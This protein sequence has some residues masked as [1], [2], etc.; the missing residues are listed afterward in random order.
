[1]LDTPMLQSAYESAELVIYAFILITLMRKTKFE[2]F[3]SS[4]NVSHKSF[5]VLTCGKS[6]IYCGTQ[7][8]KPVLLSDE[9]HFTTIFRGLARNADTYNLKC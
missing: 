8:M 9:N 1:M 5:V 4:Y 2:C 6:L 3:E 7:Y